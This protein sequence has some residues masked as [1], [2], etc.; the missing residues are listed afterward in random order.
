MADRLPGLLL[1]AG[2][3]TGQGQGEPLMVDQSNF[4]TGPTRSTGIVSTCEQAGDWAVKMLVWA[5]LACLA[6]GR[7]AETG[8]QPSRETNKN[9]VQGEQPSK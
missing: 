8:S 6:C 1:P 9:E 2:Q 3:R 7:W 4:S 5:C